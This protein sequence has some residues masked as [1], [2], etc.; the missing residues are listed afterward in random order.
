MQKFESNP[1]Q[2][3][4]SPFSGKVA[5][6]VSKIFLVVIYSIYELLNLNTSD[7]VR[8]FELVESLGC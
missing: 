3:A 5:S 7:R 4:L 8:V 1:R 6:V 2:K